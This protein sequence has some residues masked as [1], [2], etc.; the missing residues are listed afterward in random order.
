MYCLL[1]PPMLFHYTSFETLKSI[2]RKPSSDKGLC[3]WASR[4]DCF[5]DK[6]EYKL[7]ISTIKR[8]L[9]LLEMR[10]QPDR[11]IAPAFEWEEIYKNETLPF[12]YI[13]SFTDRNDNN[14]MWENY[15][16]KGKGVAIELDDTQRIVNKYTKHLVVKKCIYL[17]ENTDEELYKEIENE[18]IN[19]AFAALSSQHKNIAFALLSKYP[20]LFV[21]LIG[22][23]LLSYVAPRIKGRPYHMEEETRAILAA[24][25]R[26]VEKYFKDI[27]GI[28]KAFPDDMR[29]YKHFMKSEKTRTR[30]NGE[31]VYYQ[32]I[33]LP[34]NILKKVYVKDAT[35]VK[36]AEEVLEDK[37]FR[38]VNV[39][40][41]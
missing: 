18:Y 24:P 5:G 36:Q 20:Q 12:P 23:Y 31:T 38:D 37:G 26:E 11:R 41:L 22:R 3:F 17:G 8:L 19:S 2:V 6:D 14:Y 27:E 30:P 4:F 40:C 13:V 39:V 7:G 29:S 25:R 34:A 35:L 21:A 28:I 32:E 33:F 15:A 10:L 16:C 1:L 9:P